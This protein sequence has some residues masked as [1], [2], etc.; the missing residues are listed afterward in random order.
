MN[1]LH[2]KIFLL[3]T[4]LSAFISADVEKLKVADGFKIATYTESIENPRQMVEGENFIFVGSRSAGKVHIIDKVNPNDVRVLLT[5]LS[6]PTGVAIKD[7][8]LFIAEIDQIIVVENVEQQIN[9]G[10]EIISKVHFDDLPRKGM[11]NP[12]K[13]FHH[14]WKWI[15]FGP[16]GALY[17]SEGVPCNVC[18]DTDSR[19]G[20][21]LKLQEDDLTIYADG[22]RNSVGFEWHPI[23]GEM[24]FTDNGRD[25]MGDDIP[26]CELNKVSTNGEHFGFPFFHGKGIKDDKFI[27]NDSFKFTRPVWEFQA[28][29]APLGVKFYSGNMFPD[30]YKNGLF[31][32]QHGS[33]NRSSKVGYEVLFMKFEDNQVVSAETFMTGWLVG[34]EYWGRPAAPLMLKD[35]SMLISDDHDGVIYRVTYEG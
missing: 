23:T 12:V 9:S 17:I 21:I 29:S 14:G 3:I 26:P 7:G 30:H 2:K 28:H 1:N 27:A 25:W 35:G 4:L 34:E 6:L 33:W 18:D 19:F 31:V 8:H 32:A 15:D 10:G 5:D 13:K 24:Y 20:T 22:V 11:L 16:D